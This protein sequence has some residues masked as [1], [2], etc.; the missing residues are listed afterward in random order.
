[1]S[2]KL[3]WGIL[4]TGNI[5]NQFATA[6]SSMDDAEIAA[7]GSRS[8]ATADAFAEKYGIARRHASYEALAADPEVD[9]IYVS[10]P[11]GLHKENTLLCIEHGKGV[12]CE[13]PFTLNRKDAEEVFAA[14]RAKGVFVMEAMWTRFIPAVRQAMKWI[15]EG[16]IGE[17]RMVQSSF[18]F[19]WDGTEA[20]RLFEPEMGGGSLLDVGIY[21]ITIAHLAFGGAPSA[22]TGIA[23][24]GESGV[25]EQAGFVLGYEGG[26]L[27]VLSSAI[28]TETPYDAYILGTLGKI[29]LHST[30]WNAE[31]VSL[32]IGEGDWETQTFPHPCNGFEYEA[33]EAQRCF[34]EG[35]IESETMSHAITL[36][37]MGIMDTLRS[38]WG[39]RYPGE[40]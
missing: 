29:K 22:M 7:V 14:A 38:Q 16:R 37:V 24:L 27:A 12:V 39:L 35:R 36:E 17:V 11:H 6:L 10:T 21:P 30:F 19:A 25:D 8:Q 2:E 33:M 20:G 40:D 23:H 15:A 34:R 9:L 1:M 13:K 5:A 31:K 26:G 28:L 32:Q 4:G 18:G 3:R